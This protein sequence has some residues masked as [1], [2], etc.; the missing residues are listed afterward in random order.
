F[1][2]NHEFLIP[3]TNQSGF[4]NFFEIKVDLGDGAFDFF[5]M[6]FTGTRLNLPL[7]I[8]SGSGLNWINVENTA[9]TA[10]VTI[11]GS[12]GTDFLHVAF[13][14]QDLRTALG[15]VNIIAGSGHTSLK[16]NDDVSTLTDQYTATST[17]VHSLL[18]GD[19]TFNHLS[20]LDIWGG[21]GV[22]T[23]NV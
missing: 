7:T 4:L 23:Y 21:K 5:D 13:H 9:A 19:I 15:A 17:D 10:P 11:T 1:V 6:P 22:K 2:D 20:W 12:N 3:L 16:L 14:V 8:L 18:S